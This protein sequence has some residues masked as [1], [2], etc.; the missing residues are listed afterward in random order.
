MNKRIYSIWKAMKTRC[1]N[2]NSPRYKNYGERGVRVCNEWDKSY[3]NFENWALQNGYTDN[4]SIDRI[5][6]NGN[7]EPNNC[8]WAT[9]KEQAR[10]RTDNFFI[11]YNNETLILC[12]FAK[13]YNIDSHTLKRRLDAGWSIQDAITIKPKNVKSKVQCIENGM[14]FNSIHD[15]SIWANIPDSN[16]SRVC[17][18]KSITA[19]GYHWEYV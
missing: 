8:R 4:L 11:T 18:K 6:V 15:A 16:I 1:K 2:P 9:S 3:K 12:D 10:N 17:R 13:K 7:Y 14:I 5:D 19:G